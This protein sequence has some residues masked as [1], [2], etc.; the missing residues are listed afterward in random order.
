M[1]SPHIHKCRNRLVVPKRVHF[2]FYDKGHDKGQQ[3]EPS[4]INE[5]PLFNRS[6]LL[7]TVF[8]PEVESNDVGRCPFKSPCLRQRQQQQPPLGSDPETA[9][10]SAAPSPPDPTAAGEEPYHSQPESRTVTGMGAGHWRDFLEGWRPCGEAR[11]CRGS[12]RG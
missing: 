1:F 3:L 10:S 5:L 12:F 7:I 6:H 4:T 2:S 9:A 11:W 8:R